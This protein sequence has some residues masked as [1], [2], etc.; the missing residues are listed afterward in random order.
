M[1]QGLVNPMEAVKKPKSLVGGV[2]GQLIRDKNK[3][4]NS[5]KPTKN[6][7]KVDTNEST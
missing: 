3:K 4:P 1:G 5:D 6:K 7:T 2:A